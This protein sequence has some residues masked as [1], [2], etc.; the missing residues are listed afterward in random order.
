MIKEDK[1][2]RIAF[3]VGS[4]PKISETF[5]LNQITGLIDQGHNVTII[6]DENPKDKKTHKKVIEYNLLE[7]TIY[8]NI[9]KNKG[10]RLIGA[11]PI[12]AKLLLQR[13]FR[14]LQTLNFFKYGRS[15]LSLVLFYKTARIVNT[16]YDIAHCH[17]GHNGFFG[18][19]LKD[20]G[21]AQKIVVTFHGY[22][23]H[24]YP[25]DQGI[26]VYHKL[27]PNTDLV[28]CNTTFTKN[29]VV[30]LGCNPSKIRILPVGLDTRRFNEVKKIQNHGEI[31]ILTI[32]RLVEKKGHKYSLLALSKLPKGIRFKYTIVGDGP[33]REYLTK[34]TNDLNLQD[35]VKFLGERTQEEIIKFYGRT[36]I[37]LLSAVQA[38]NG[39]MEGQALVLQEAQYCKI[40]IIS[41]FHNGIPEGVIDEQTGYLVKEKDTKGIRDK[42]LYLIQN[43]KKRKIMG[44][45]GRR[46]VQQR[47]EIGQ[48][49]KQLIQLYEE[50]I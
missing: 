34:L 1:Q 27:F 23:A 12:I 48:L 6:A 18:S 9:P 16:K 4:F 20:L 32:G 3:I 49:N 13:K 31:R 8:A 35:K 5:I 38:K 14:I 24:M 11:F 30:K 22:D 41:T 2:M 47:Y 7:K 37:F 43:P 19:F 44:L 46:F 45:Q 39:D 15:A 21:I 25:R 29:K 36:D 42:L 17:F 50:V 33:L 26:K 40:P 28:T 10:L